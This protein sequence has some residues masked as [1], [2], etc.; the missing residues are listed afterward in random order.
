MNDE[1]NKKIYLYR[2]AEHQCYFGAGL[3]TLSC[4]LQYAECKNLNFRMS[5]DDKWIL[6]P[7]IKDGKQQQQNWYYYFEPIETDEKDEKDTIYEN[8]K[9]NHMTDESGKTIGFKESDFAF[10][11]KDKFNNLHDYKKYLLKKIYKPKNWIKNIAYQKIKDLNLPEKYYAI[12]VR[13]TDKINSEGHFHKLDEYIKPIY[14]KWIST[15]RNDSTKY[16]NKPTIY[17]ST[18]ENCE[19]ILN[20]LKTSTYYNIFN[21]VLDLSENRY[22]NGYVSQARELSKTEKAEEEVITA[23]KNIDLLIN[24]EYMVGSRESFFFIICILLGNNEYY[25]LAENYACPM[26]DGLL[27]TKNE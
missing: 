26:R 9:I 6:V 18:D 1:K 8:F 23:I 15:N 13:R 25:S 22:N 2:I 27:P 20:E 3:I 5:Y 17:I 10:Y 11:P 24:S 19:S 14:Y 21:F 7:E 16:N 4:A 12:H